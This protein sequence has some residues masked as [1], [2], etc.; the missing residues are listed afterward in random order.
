[1]T[2]KEWREGTQNNYSSSIIIWDACK[3]K[4]P[5]EVMYVTGKFNLWIF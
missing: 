4:K 1:M 5:T 2:W 3:A